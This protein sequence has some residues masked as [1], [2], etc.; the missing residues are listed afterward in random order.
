M[1]QIQSPTRRHICRGLALAGLGLIVSPL[2]AGASALGETA[3]R[4][5][6]LKSK[7]K[8]LLVRAEHV[9]AKFPIALG[10]HPVGAKRKQGDK[11]TPEG[12]YRIDALN[13]N[14]RYYRALHISYPNAED[15]R[16][17]QAAGVAPG[18]DIE[19]HG[20]PEAYGTYDPVVFVKDWTD[21][22]IAVSNR[23]MDEIWTRVQ[24]DTAVDIIA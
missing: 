24:V 23:T 21:G 12:R 13:P 10:A 18:G 7:R 4:I 6:V 11:R 16:W 1:R 14:S 20:M 3:D 17:A 9:I 22:C 15:I 19:I 2:S 8:L 5:V